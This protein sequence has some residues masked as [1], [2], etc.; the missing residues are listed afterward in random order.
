VTG[1]RCY[2]TVTGDRGE[3]T[4]DRGQGTGDRGQGRGDRGEGIGNR[5]RGTGEREEIIKKIGDRIRI[6][7]FYCLLPLLA[8]C[9]LILQILSLICH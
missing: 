5:G 7:N 3:G 4:G 6:F 9:I 2:A 1:D 8:L